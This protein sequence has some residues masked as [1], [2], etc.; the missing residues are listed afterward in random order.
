MARKSMAL[1]ALATLS[2]VGC[3]AADSSNQA[4]E[5]AASAYQTT[6]APNVSTS[7][8]APAESTSSSSSTPSQSATT[9][10]ASTAESSA[11]TSNLS[12][13]KANSYLV[14]NDFAGATSDWQDGLYHIAE[15]SEITGIGTKLT[16]CIST[17]DHND[18]GTSSYSNDTQTLRLNLGHKFETLQ[19]EVGQGNDSQ[20]L[21]QELAVRIT[22]GSKQIG[23]ISTV[24]FDE[25]KTVEVPVKDRNVIFLQFYMPATAGESCSSE[26]IIPVIFNVELN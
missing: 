17:P 1:V 8:A 22:D 21:N 18:M 4:V 15:K 14:L 5:T 24:R 25:Y 23:E 12:T 16:S 3:G 13:E 7:T 26:S 19:F 20:S 6:Q 11:Y 10:A 2:L 9:L